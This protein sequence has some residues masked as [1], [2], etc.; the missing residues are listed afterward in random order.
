M[1]KAKSKTSDI[2]QEYKRSDLGAGVRGKFYAQFRKGH[3][4]VLLKPEVAAAFPTD[5]AVN[6][7][8]LS[9]VRLA[10]AARRPTRRS[11]GRAAQAPRA[12]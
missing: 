2:R 9:L 5:D 4:L 6:D 3:N 8:L 1:T 10:R 7:A 12:V 11:T